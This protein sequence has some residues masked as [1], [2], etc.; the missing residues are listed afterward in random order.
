MSEFEAALTHAL[1]V[2]D[3]QID[4]QST[5]WWSILSVDEFVMILQCLAHVPMQD[6]LVQA[7]VRDVAACACT[8]RFAHLAL[9][10]HASWLRLEM[11][12][13]REA[14]GV[15]GFGAFDIQREVRDYPYTHHRLLDHRSR[16]DVTMF[17]KALSGMVCHCALDTCQFNCKRV[18]TQHNLMLLA[19]K[20]SASILDLFCTR[21]RTSRLKQVW[22]TGVAI[23]VSQQNA[24][25]VLTRHRNRVQHSC[26]HTLVH[27]VDTHRSVRHSD[28]ELRITNHWGLLAVDSESMFTHP[29]L[30]P[31]GTHA[32]VVE[33]RPNASSHRLHVFVLDVT[34]QESTPPFPF[35][36]YG[37]TIV[38][39]KRPLPY[40]WC[41][42]DLYTVRYE[43]YN[44]RSCISL[45]TIDSSGKMQSRPVAVFANT[46]I[47]AIRACA[48]GT[49]ACMLVH[50]QHERDGVRRNALKLFDALQPSKH[51]VVDLKASQ[52]VKIK[53]GVVS[54]NGCFV[55]GI[56]ECK[57][58]MRESL[59]VY[60][61]HSSSDDTSRRPFICFES[62]E[63]ATLFRDAPGRVRMCNWMTFSPC[64]RFLAMTVSFQ[65]HDNTFSVVVID[66]RG[67]IDDVMRFPTVS[68]QIPL[69]LKWSEAGLWLVTK[70]GVLL[71]GFQT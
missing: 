25:L 64:S 54:P 58:R 45:N 15:G 32:A 34:P 44:D 26:T 69:D 40:W 20:A 11:V 51:T 55:V 56:V 61:R 39:G 17:Q 71:I 14:G 18:R 27:L 48:G 35:P 38:D 29:Q 41:G 33:I 8:C 28:T 3:V 4:A 46:E 22:S 66:L 60:K 16:I 7:S 13:R 1:A 47:I 70:R 6:A 63:L 52:Y 5:G 24:C 62:R 30:N 21:N 10:H 31:K 9:W 36:V 23:D 42:E 2:H 49:L 12:A 68:D 65:E 53:A 50:L 59:C 37:I 67:T 43:K 19:A 57:T